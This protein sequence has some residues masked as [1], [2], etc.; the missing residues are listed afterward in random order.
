M[1]AMIGNRSEFIYVASCTVTATLIVL[2]NNGVSASDDGHSKLTVKIKKSNQTAEHSNT[3]LIEGKGRL[4]PTAPPLLKGRVNQDV[5]PAKLNVNLAKP[6][7]QVPSVTPQP[8]EGNANKNSLP[9]RLNANLAKP[10]VRL[11]SSPFVQ[12]GVRQFGETMSNGPTSPNWQAGINCIPTPTD[13]EGRKQWDTLENELRSSQ[14]F[15]EWRL[16]VDNLSLLLLNEGMQ[17]LTTD[18]VGM[19]C[20]TVDSGGRLTVQTASARSTNAGFEASSRT[21]IDSLAHSS[22]LRFPPDSHVSKVSANITLS[23]T[24]GSS[25]F[26]AH[27]KGTPKITGGS[28]EYVTNQFIINHHTFLHPFYYAP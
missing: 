10:N 25:S 15:D 1:L 19:F 28:D 12:Q 24:T 14:L 7:T 2:L 6:S 23:R 27:Y 3:R 18:G 8:L 26:N 11:D 17:K 4:A 13:P 22:V 21:I 20:V 5:I 16:W 9:A